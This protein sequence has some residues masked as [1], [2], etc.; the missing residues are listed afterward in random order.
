MMRTK[1][2]RRVE[3]GRRL[4]VGSLLFGLVAACGGDGTKLPLSL[5]LYGP[6]ED[7]QRPLLSFPIEVQP[8]IDEVVVTAYQGDRV[9]GESTRA[10]V[11]EGTVR[12]HVRLLIERTGTR[13]SQAAAA[14]AALHWNCCLRGP[15]V[16]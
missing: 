9:I 5:S 4:L 11:S 8:L 15:A 7:G 13:N 12:K 3:F 10:D 2:M 16:S 1:H 6:S 14:W